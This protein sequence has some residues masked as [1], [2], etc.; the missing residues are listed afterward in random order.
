MG[1]TRIPN[2]GDQYAKINERIHSSGAPV[3]EVL[4]G[5]RDSNGRPTYPENR[6]RDGHGHWIALEIDGLYQIIYWRHPE[7]E[8]GGLEYGSD[9]HDNPLCDLEA[10]ISEKEQLC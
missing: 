2:F 8:G 9:S 3:V 7:Y 6:R 5:A 4:Y 1:F 10:D